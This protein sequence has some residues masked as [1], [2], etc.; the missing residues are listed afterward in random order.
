MNQALKQ[1]LTARDVWIRGLYMLLFAFI[2]GVAEL[3]VVTLVIIQFLIRLLTGDTN[4]RLLAFG[5]GLS[6][7]IYQILLFL[8]FNTE[9][10]PFPFAE[11]PADG[12]REPLDSPLG[13]Q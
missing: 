1:R 9:E 7:Y 11:W 3:V 6:R 4:D 2:Y 12:E 8:T 13:D 5:R 10:K